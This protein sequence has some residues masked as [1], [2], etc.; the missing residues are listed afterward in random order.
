M[1][2]LKEKLRQYKALPSQASVGINPYNVEYEL[3]TPSLPHL[4]DGKIFNDFL[5]LTS[6]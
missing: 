4:Y 3:G 6:D 2:K 1:E 5:L